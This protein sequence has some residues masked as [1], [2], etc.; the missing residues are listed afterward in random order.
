MKRGCID[1]EKFVVNLV[2][3]CGWG[4]G[5]GWGFIVIL[6]SCE[7]RFIRVHENLLE[8]PNNNISISVE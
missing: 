1:R 6:T 3:G 5:G 2:C 7:Y 8:H 4:K